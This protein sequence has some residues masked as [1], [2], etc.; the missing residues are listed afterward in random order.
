M[1]GEGYS[2]QSTEDLEDIRS[3]L[4]QLPE[5]PVLVDGRINREVLHRTET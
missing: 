3:N 2:V 4:S 5:N 1:G